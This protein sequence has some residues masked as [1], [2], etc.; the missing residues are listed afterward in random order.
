MTEK[1][2]SSGRVNPMAPLSSLVGSI[3]E[4]GFPENKPLPPKPS[5]LPFPV[6]RHRSH[7][8]VSPNPHFPLLGFIL[9]GVD[10]FFYSFIFLACGEQTPT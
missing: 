2:Q 5:R 9:L 3:V 10:G 6:A 8:P 7:G 4:K 1:E